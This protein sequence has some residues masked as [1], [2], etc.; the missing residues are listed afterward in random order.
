MDGVVYGAATALGFA[1]LE[2]LRYGL[3][4]GWD[5][6]LLRAFTTLPGH[7]C[8]G[9]LMEY[10]VGQARCNSQWLS[11]PLRGF[12]VAVLLHG[13]YDFPLLSLKKLE[14]QWSYGGEDLTPAAW[15]WGMAGAAGLV[16]VGSWIW[17]MVIVSRLRREQERAETREASAIPSSGGVISDSG[18]AL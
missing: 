17:T 11:S 15:V 1:V 12:A 5:V 13:L 7:A 4:E 3:A 8:W 10:Y 9:A 6:V 18:A 14:T 16:N 2:N